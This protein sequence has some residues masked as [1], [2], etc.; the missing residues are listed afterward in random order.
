MPLHSS[1]LPDSENVE[2]LGGTDKDD[3]ELDSHAQELLREYLANNSEEYRRLRDLRKKGWENS[4]G[5]KYFKRQ[6]QTA[7][8]PDEKM[9]EFF[10]NMMKNIAVLLY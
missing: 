7:D 5:D 10:Y 4:Q 6:R 8:A 9:H 3:S 1:K 2:R